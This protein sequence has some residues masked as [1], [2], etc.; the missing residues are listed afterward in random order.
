MQLAYRDRHFIEQLLAEICGEKKSAG[1]PLFRLP[2]WPRFAALVRR[3]RLGALYDAINWN[4]ML[5]DP[6][7]ALL[8]REDNGH[9]LQ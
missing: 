4:F 3:Q 5:P 9:M 8:E 2:N 7:T 6:W 1:A